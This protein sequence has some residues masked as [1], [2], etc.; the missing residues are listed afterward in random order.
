[1]TK[2]FRETRTP[3]DQEFAEQVRIQRTKAG[4]TQEALAAAM[5]A[6]GHAWKQTTVSS[7]ERCE[8]GVR[9][10]EVFDL[11]AVLG[12]RP[13]S[14]LHPADSV[15]QPGELADIFDQRAGS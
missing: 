12:V 4:L 13:G 3:G 2:H 9:V 11:A 8:R 5:G 14:L 7:V 1:M 15:L 10:G 6:R